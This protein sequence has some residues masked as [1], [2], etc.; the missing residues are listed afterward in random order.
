MK[1]KTRIFLLLIDSTR[2]TH[3]HKVRKLRNSRCYTK[4]TLRLVILGSSRHPRDFLPLFPQSAPWRYVS[5]KR[6][7][8]EPHFPSFGIDSHPIWKQPIRMFSIFGID[9]F[10][11]EFVTWNA[12]KTMVST[13]MLINIAYT[14]TALMPTSFTTMMIVDWP[15]WKPNK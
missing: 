6:H 4:V 1:T 9:A 13:P 8:V 3:T 14:L 2:H 5:S 7:N 11:T 12:R 10:I 15:Y